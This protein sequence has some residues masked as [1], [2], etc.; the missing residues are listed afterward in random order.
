MLSNRYLS[1]ITDLT[2]YSWP[3]EHILMIMTR[4][5]ETYFTVSGL[6][7]AFY[8][9]PLSDDLHTQFYRRRHTVHVCTRRYLWTLWTS[10]LFLVV[11]WLYILSLSSKGSNP[12]PIL[13]IV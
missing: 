5:K 3:L 8:Q 1:F 12:S 11:S 6:S 9:V 10:K 4:I 2:N 7:C 13:M